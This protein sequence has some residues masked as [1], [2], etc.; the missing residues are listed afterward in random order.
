MARSPCPY[1]EA[2]GVKRFGPWWLPDAEEHIP[3]W[4]LAAKQVRD[5][6]HA[7]QLNKYTEAIKHCTERR[8]AVDIGAHVG[9][10]SYWM[11]KD[12][13]ALVAFE[14]KPEHQECWRLNVTAENAILHPVALGN[15]Q[16][17]VSLNNPPKSSGDSRIEPEVP[18]DIEMMRLDDFGIENCDFL[19]IDCE[20][21]EAPIIEGG[22]QTIQRCRPVIIVEQ[23]PGHAQRFGRRP[24]EA[25]EILRSWG[26]VLVREM[27]GDY[28]M[29]YPQ[30]H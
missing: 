4:M 5:H 11:A 2:D 16:G 29:R 19:K 28:I 12:F 9:L 22:E 3:E 17:M 10:W 7:Y 15:A 23:K 30:P 24:T 14:P 1:G 27:V 8:L 25:V 20:G 21:Y 6:R 18:G 13:G 26:F